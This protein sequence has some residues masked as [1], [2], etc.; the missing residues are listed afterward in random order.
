MKTAEGLSAAS[1]AVLEG[2]SRLLKAEKIIRLLSTAI[3]LDGKRILDIGT[4]SG[5]I[6]AQLAA[7]VG[8]DGEVTSIDVIDERVERQGFHFLTVNGAALPFPD[9]SFDV[10]ISN[11]IIEH[12]GDRQAQ[13]LHLAEIRRVLKPS[14][15]CYF[16][17]AHRWVVKEPHYG[18]PFLS[19]LPGRLADRYLQL[20]RLGRHYDCDLPSHWRLR[21]LFDQAALS[22]EDHRL[23]A[24]RYLA[25]IESNSSPLAS[26]AARLPLWVLR[27]LRPLIPT[28]V[29]LLRP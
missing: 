9:R 5:I 3:D 27:P 8:T 16:A 4:G 26:L 11:H 22:A 20:T 14:G 7:A 18:L 24:L 28:Q 6:A 21:R 2:R 10:V 19:W 1:H 25:A 23:D 15:L 17:V 12:V 29:Y 13:Q